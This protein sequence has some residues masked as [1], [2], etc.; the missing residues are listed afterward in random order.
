M[1]DTAV[2]WTYREG[3]VQITTKPEEIV[4]IGTEL[5]ELGRAGVMYTNTK[6]KEI[7]VWDAIA[8][9][10]VVVANKTDELSAEEIVALFNI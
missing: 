1:I 2:L 5:P 10:Y 7:S 3:W 9:A 8:G 4:F 6:R